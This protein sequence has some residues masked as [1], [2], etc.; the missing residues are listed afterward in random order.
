MGLVRHPSAFGPTR[1]S[2][3]RN[4]AGFGLMELMI[5]VALLA[6]LST[7]AF[8]SY[9]KVM[10]KTYRASAASCL[11]QV[12]QQ[13][14]RFYAINM[15]YAGAGDPAVAS[16]AAPLADSYRFT[17]VRGVPTTYRVTA[18]P[19]PNQAARDQACG[20]LWLSHSG[21]RGVTGDEPADKCW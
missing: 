11:V 20:S 19:L 10:A 5:V 1:A 13:M 17:L 9:T 6:G 16:C 4:A 15:T 3:A 7:I 14:E 2:S 12:A 21:E 8:T 18:V